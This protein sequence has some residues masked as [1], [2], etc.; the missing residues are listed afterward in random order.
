MVAAAENDVIGRDGDLPWHLPGDLRWF[1]ELTTGGVVVAG[2]LTHESIVRRLG[3]PLP[4]RI[5]VVVSSGAAADGTHVVPARSAREGLDRARALA[6]WGGREEVFVI[7]GARVYAETLPEVDRIHL[8]RV[9]AEVDGDAVLPAG[10]LTGFRLVD[11]RPGPEDAPLPY[12]HQV[13]ERG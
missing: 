5:T 3:R 11:S 1:R 6:A 7:G 9:H 13:Y 4:G 10:W 2:R 12:S 8:T